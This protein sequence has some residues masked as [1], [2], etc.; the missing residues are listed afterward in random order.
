MLRIIVLL[1]AM[2]TCNSLFSQEKKHI[3]GAKGRYVLSGSTTPDEAK[4]KATAE[5]KLEALR[6]AGVVEHISS[7]EF[8]F[9]SEIGSSYDEVYL[10]DIQRE[11]RGAIQDYT[12][13]AKK[14]VDAGDN[15]FVEVNLSADVLMFSTSPDPTLVA[16]IEGLE[17]FYK[18][19]SLLK[20][21]ITPK[22]NC[23]L[24]IFNLYDKNAAL[25]FPNKWETAQLQKADIKYFYPNSSIDYPLT[26]S[27][28]SP[29]K[30]KMIFVFTKDLIPYTK[31]SGEDQNTSF[32]DISSWLLS[33]PP[34]RRF[35]EYH[36]FV[37][38]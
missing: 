25:T 37:I 12:V 23:Y 30:N 35:V 4:I 29:E 24:T 5:A 26:R 11:M 32:E 15:F 21:T 3:N 13:E 1:M 9:K 34:D 6:M 20:F 10:S 19:G 28:N 2:V 17:P 38:Y 36:S 18:E 7:Y 31:F 16:H 33:I 22:Q 27:I 8:L 14:G